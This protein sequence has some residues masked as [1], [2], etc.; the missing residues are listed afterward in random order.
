MSRRLRLILPLLLA[1]APAAHAQ[2]K[3][4]T[5]LHAQTCND[6]I[7]LRDTVW[8]ATGEAGLVRF[9]RSDSTWSSIT[10]EPN[11][12]AGNTIQAITFDRTKRYVRYVGTIAGTS[13]SFALA[14][15]ISEQKKQL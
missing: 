2:G 5:Y 12:L 8:L 7:A 13:P 6:I 15:V 10:R 11:G 14:V 1:L 9:R 4:T 3:W